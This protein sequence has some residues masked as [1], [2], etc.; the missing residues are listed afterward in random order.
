MIPFFSIKNLHL[1]AET[2]L[3]SAYQRVMKSGYFVLGEEVSQFE[4]EFAAYCQ[5][6]HCI[7]V[8]N[9]LDAL[10]LILRGLDIGKGDEVITVLKLPSPRKRKQLLQCIYTVSPPT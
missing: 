6:K 1:E 5:A 8:G 10:H 3:N 4:Q 9:G 7:G 2:E